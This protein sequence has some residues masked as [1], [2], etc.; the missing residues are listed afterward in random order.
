LW[1]VARGEKEGGVGFP[2][3]MMTEDMEG[4][5]AVAKS[6]RHLFGRTALDEKGAQGLVLAV[7]G[8]AGFQEEAAKLT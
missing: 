5:E 3:E 6:L 1:S 7:L 4:I 2:A 8:Q